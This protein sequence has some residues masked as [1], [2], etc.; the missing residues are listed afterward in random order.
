M[1]SLG[2]ERILPVGAAKGHNRATKIHT[3][4]MNCRAPVLGKQLLQTPNP[5]TRWFTTPLEPSRASRLTCCPTLLL[6]PSGDEL[7]PSPSSLHIYA[8]GANADLGTVPLCS[9]SK[10][11]PTGRIGFRLAVSAVCRLTRGR[12]HAR[13]SRYKRALHRSAFFVIA[14][15][16]EGQDERLQR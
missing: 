5:I 3:F 14:T 2:R 10:F 6:S 11:P 8:G 12:T 4:L 1:R 15:S 7:S 13:T 16:G 9:K